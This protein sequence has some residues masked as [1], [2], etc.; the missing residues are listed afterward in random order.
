MPR[1][2]PPE[3][4]WI[5]SG[6]YPVLRGI[7]RHPKMLTARQQIALFGRVVVRRGKL[8]ETGC[9]RLKRVSRKHPRKKARHDAPGRT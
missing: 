2:D 5:A 7:T 1:R 8:G 4:I 3:W 9:F 6:L